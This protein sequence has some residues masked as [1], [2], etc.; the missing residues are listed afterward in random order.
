MRKIAVLLCALVLILCM[1]I[2]A[3]SAETGANS[4]NIYATVSPDG[5]CQVTATVL[6]HLEQ[7]VGTLM[8]PVPEDAESITVNGARVRAVKSGNTRQVD[9]SGIVNA[10]DPQ[11]TQSS[12]GGVG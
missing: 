12:G 3:V 7:A 6:L 11:P 2:G 4:V 9:L 5:S 10:R 8:F 1:T